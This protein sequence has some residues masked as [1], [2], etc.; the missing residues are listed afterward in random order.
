MIHID[1]NEKYWLFK[2]F[3]IESLYLGDL[4]EIN[5]LLQKQ[6]QKDYL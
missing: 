6:M 3:S 5:V 4:L 1:K 2:Q